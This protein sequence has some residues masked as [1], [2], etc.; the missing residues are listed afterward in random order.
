VTRPGS[1][2]KVTWSTAVWAPYRLVTSSTRIIARRPF[3]R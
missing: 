2:V 1:A 3:R